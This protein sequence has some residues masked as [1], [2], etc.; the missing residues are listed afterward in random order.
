MSDS[1][2]EKSAAALS[3]GLGAA[4]DP[5]AYPG[6]AHYLEHMLF[7]G[8]SQYPEP[9][10]FMAF[11]AEHGGMS[12]AYTGLAITHYRM[13]VE[14]EA[15]P[16]AL[17]RFSSFFTDPLLDPTYIDKEERGQRRVVHA[18][19]AGF[20]HYLPV[21]EKAS[22]DHPANRFQIG[23][24]ESLADKTQGGL[25]D[26]T[27][28]FFEQ[29]YSAN[30]MKASL[31]GNLPLAELRQLAE[32]HF[33][34]IPNKQVDRPRTT[35]SSTSPWR[36]PS[37]SDTGHRTIP[38]NCG[39]IS[40]SMTTVICTTPSPVSTWPTSWLLRCPIRR[41]QAARVGWAS[42]LV[43]SADPARYGNYGLFT[44]S[45]Q[46]TPEGLGHRDAITTMLLGYVD[47][48]REQGIDDRYAEE[49]GTSLANRF[50]FLEKMDEFTYA[51]ELT[52]AMQTYPARYAMSPYRFTGFDKQAVDTVLAQLIPERLH[53]W[54]ID[55]AQPVS[56]SLRFY[57]G[58]Y[59]VEPLKLPTPSERRAQVAQY[60][61]KL[62]RKIDCCLSN[63]SC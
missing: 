1:S 7:M 51:H 23:N 30:L 57:D 3:V 61:L 44:F 55:Q 24:L 12:T 41:G 21:V 53:L 38:A 60:G 14:T 16:E 35:L 58:Q 39:W 37:A 47:M 28:A 42:S 59:S 31:V 20:P 10:G 50:Q 49:F 45:V 13:R 5:E 19:G 15:F 2:A 25:H 6:M 56:E 11:T 52:R 43:V 26:A 22:G 34:E 63:L 27:V 8:S 4:S 17:D 29:Y 33:G 54:E 18:P 36:E 46:L 9:D 48:L 62:P 40:L 32:K